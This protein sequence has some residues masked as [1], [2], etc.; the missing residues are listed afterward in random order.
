MSKLS[1]V[2]RHSAWPLAIASTHHAS[3]SCE[4]S[5]YRTQSLGRFALLLLYPQRKRPV[6]PYPANVDNM[7]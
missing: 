1:Y 3:S 5:V 6:N 4:M 7:V 2:L